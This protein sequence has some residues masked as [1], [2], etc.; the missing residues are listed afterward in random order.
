MTNER[1]HYMY[2]G[3]SVGSFSKDQILLMLNSGTLSSSTLI[4]TQGA[5]DWKPIKDVFDLDSEL[6]PPIP[7]A[8]NRNKT[9]SSSS[10]KGTAWNDTSP[11]PWRRYF[12]RMVDTSVNGA[13]AFFFIS[14]VWHTLDSNSANQFFNFLNSP[15]LQFLNIIATVFVAIFVN[16]ALIGFTGGSIGKWFF[17]IKVL[18]ADNRPIQYARAIKRE[19]SIWLRGLGLG[20][21]IVSLFTLIFSYGELRK[22]G[23]TNWDKDMGLKVLYRDSGNRQTILCGIGI[24]L[25]VMMIGISAILK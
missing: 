8:S 19:F 1:W 7:P 3:Q 12:A 4:W 16:A 9:S 10:E 17:G 13:M 6:P 23:A 15:S 24:L 5:E 18:G 25:F 2:N 20:I 14:I 21:P 11:H 22:Q